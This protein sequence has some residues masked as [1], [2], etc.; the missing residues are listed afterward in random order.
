MGDVGIERSGVRHSVAP[1]ECR[2][3]RECYAVQRTVQANGAT[4]DAQGPRGN[5]SQIARRSVM[6]AARRIALVVH[7]CSSTALSPSVSGE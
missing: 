2:S 3:A 5:R 7:A 4:R 1:R 6:S